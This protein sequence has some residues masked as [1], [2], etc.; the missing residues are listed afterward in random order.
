MKATTKASNSTKQAVEKVRTAL[1]SLKD[2]RAKSSTHPPPSADPHHEW[3]KQL[4]EG[5]IA[6][7][8]QVIDRLFDMQCQSLT[9][10]QAR[11]ESRKANQ[12]GTSALCARCEVKPVVLMC[13]ECGLNYCKD[14]SDTVHSKGRLKEHDLKSAVCESCEKCPASVSCVECDI[15]YCQSCSASMHLK[16]KLQEHKRQSL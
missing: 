14:C 8:D 10:L 13:D 2:S 1:E 12:P 5:R 15:L 9:Q 7:A 16:G 11:S 3:T 4:L 6:K